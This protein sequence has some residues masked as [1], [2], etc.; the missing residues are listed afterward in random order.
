MA[1]N[2]T[3]KVLT[4]TLEIEVNGKRTRGTRV[5]DAY[6][7]I[8]GGAVEAAKKALPEGSIVQITA[9]PNWEYRHWHPDPQVFPEGEF[10][11]VL[12]EAEFEWEEDADES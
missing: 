4:V 3:K 1:K 11:L 5:G 2:P 8:V 10:V 7:Q 9:Q 12:D 6:N